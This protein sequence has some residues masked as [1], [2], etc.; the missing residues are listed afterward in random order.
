VTFRLPWQE[1]VDRQKKI[2][3]VFDTVWTD[4]IQDKF[5]IVLKQFQ[6]E[7]NIPRYIWRNFQTL[8]CKSFATSSWA[9]GCAEKSYIETVTRLNSE[10]S[11]N[12][13]IGKGTKISIQEGGKS[14]LQHGEVQRNLHEYSYHSLSVVYRKTRVVSCWTWEKYLILTRHPCQTANITSTNQVNLETFQ[15]YRN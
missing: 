15:I 5:L 14:S 6:D 8:P 4:Y 13:G 10:E 1:I 12:R 2:R 7:C 9:G 3:S 11:Y